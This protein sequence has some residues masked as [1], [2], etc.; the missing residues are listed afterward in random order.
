MVGEV[1]WLELSV[2]LAAIVT[3]A[4]CTHPEGR[5]VW[6]PNWQIGENGKQSV[7]SWAL[8]SQVVGNLVDSEEQVLV[9]CG[10][11]DVGGEEERP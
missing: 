1:V 9:R 11:D 8:E 6:N 5:R 4:V 7:R 10:P 3:G 2:C